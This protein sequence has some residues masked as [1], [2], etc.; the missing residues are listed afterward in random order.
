MNKEG[1]ESWLC[2]LNVWWS[3]HCIVF[4]L[5]SNLFLILQW[6]FE[7][8]L[9]RCIHRGKRFTRIRTPNPQNLKSLWHRLLFCSSKRVFPYCFL[10]KHV[11]W[12]YD[13]NVFIPG[14]VW[15]GK[16]QPRVEKWLEGSVHQFSSVRIV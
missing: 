8:N 7:I 10:V 4:V 2:L 5:M 6:S 3:Y 15:F 12:Y 14:L 11:T 9:W 13:S 1:H 16:Y